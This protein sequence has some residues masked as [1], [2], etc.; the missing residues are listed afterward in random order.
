MIGYHGERADKISWRLISEGLANIVASDA[1]QGE[2][3]RECRLDDVYAMLVRR[4]GKIAADTL[5]IENPTLLSHNK[6]L[7]SISVNKAW[8][9]K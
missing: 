2:G 8:W 9:H 5:C 1:H 6:E 7:L 3:K 4:F